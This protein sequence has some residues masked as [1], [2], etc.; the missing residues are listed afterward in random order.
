MA[1][2]STRRDFL[3]ISAVGLAASA[4]TK[5]VSAL[6]QNRTVNVWVTDDT[7][8]CSPA[9]P[10]QWTNAAAGTSVLVTLK[11]DI[12]R[13]SILGFGGAFTDAA[14]FMMNRLSTDARAK[15]LHEMFHPSQ[16]ALSVCRT[17]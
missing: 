9:K 17:C 3:K 6:P 7:T 4:S 8:K 1:S 2:E 14:C 16:M 11:P 12:R 15:L 13:Q 5:Q 10:I